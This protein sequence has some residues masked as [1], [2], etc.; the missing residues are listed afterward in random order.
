MLDWTQPFLTA[1]RQTGKVSSAARVVG[2]NPQTVYNRRKADVD[3]AAAVEEAIEECHDD[4]ETEM[5]RRARDG[6][7]EPVVYKGALQYLMEPVLDEEG[8]VVL[9][10]SGNVR[11]QPVRDSEG[12]LIPLTVSKKSDA[13]LMFALKGYRK[14]RFAERTEL[15][16]AEGSP[17]SPEVPETDR[18]ARVAA[19]LE[20]AR[21]RRDA[22]DIG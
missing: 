6:Y 7:A 18:V 9:D 1:L 4:L 14:A 21:A 11:M 3:F 5:V 19:L 2:V 13:L 8:V 17:L 12:K 16:G 15:T 22:S 10:A 20:A